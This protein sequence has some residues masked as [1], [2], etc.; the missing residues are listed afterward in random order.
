MGLSVKDQSTD[1]TWIVTGA[2]LGSAEFQPH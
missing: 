2:L 1:A